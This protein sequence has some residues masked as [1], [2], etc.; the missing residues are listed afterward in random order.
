MASNTETTTFVYRGRLQYAKVLGDPVLNYN[1][2]G[3]EWKFDFVPNDARTAEK[4]L[5]AVG[6]GDRIRSKEDYLNGEKYISFKQAELTRDGKPNRRI[7]VED[8][9]GNPWPETKLIGNG[10]VADVKFVVVDNGPGKFK[11]MYPRSIRILEHVPYERKEFDDLPE[12]DEYANAAERAQR[13]YEQFQ[14]DFGVG[15]PPSDDDLN[16]DLDGV[17][18]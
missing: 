1:K 2:D 16:D 3:N 12:D 7:R 10:S 15:E 17:L 14:R 11:G 9:A 4:E 6:K 13:E 5:K 18:D 8:A